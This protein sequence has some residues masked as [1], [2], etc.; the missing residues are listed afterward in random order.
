M[1]SLPG[2]SEAFIPELVGLEVSSSLACVG[3]FLKYVH[4]T[5]IRHEILGLSSSFTND[6]SVDVDIGRNVHTLNLLLVGLEFLLKKPPLL[7]LY[8]IQVPE[9]LLSLTI[10]PNVED[11][12]DLLISETGIALL[13]RFFLDQSPD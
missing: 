6:A 12:V 5:V 8:S 13:A 9:D 7:G 2:L 11:K 1:D 3:A 10:I 4:K